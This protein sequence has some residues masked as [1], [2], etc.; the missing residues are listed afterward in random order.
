VA[1]VLKQP[2]QLGILHCLI[3]I[4]AIVACEAIAR[5]SPGSSAY[6]LI[7]AWWATLY[8][9]A[10]FNTPWR[11]VPVFVLGMIVALAVD[12][13]AKSNLLYHDAPM[14][15]ALG[16][17]GVAAFLCILWISPFAVNSVV[18]WLR[19]KLYL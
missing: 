4:A 8:S 3:W 1:A 19:E 6:A 12:A 17:W 5:G 16:F 7:C 2:W 10:V 15:T 18:H 14:P 9:A 11:A 13:L